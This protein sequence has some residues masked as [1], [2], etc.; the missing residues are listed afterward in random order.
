M[1]GP[2]MSIV[3]GQTVRLP[4]NPVLPQSLGPPVLRLADHLDTIKTLDYTY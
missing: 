4:R 1:S 3:V 2:M